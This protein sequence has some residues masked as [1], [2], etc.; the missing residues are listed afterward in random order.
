VVKLVLVICF[1]YI[2][3]LMFNVIPE[4]P[5]NNYFLFG[6][7]DLSLKTHAYF[8]FDHVSRL[9]L[10]YVIVVVLPFTKI[11]F[12]L[13]LGDLLDYLICYNSEWFSIF[14]YG[15]EYNDLKLIIVGLWML[16]ILGLSE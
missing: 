8:A 12:W 10:F 16:W 9:M 2:V 5:A 14:G 11:L 4:T 13:E 1:S 15:F 7:I 6:G 3:G